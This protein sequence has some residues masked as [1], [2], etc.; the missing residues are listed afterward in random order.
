LVS[1]AGTAPAPPLARLRFQRG[2]VL[3]AA[4]ALILM[5]GGF[6][7][8]GPA[9]RLPPFATCSA[10]T[11][12]PIQHI[13]IVVK[14]NRSFDNMFGRFPRANGTVY[15]RAGNRVFKMSVTPDALKHD[16]GHGDVSTV[17]AMNGGRMNEFIRVSYARQ[18]VDNGRL[19]DVADSQFDEQSIPNY[20]AYARAYGLA[21]E[22]FSTI[23]ASSF[24][25]HLTTVAGS[26]LHT[27]DNPFLPVTRHGVERWQNPTTWGCDAQRGSLVHVSI[28]G[29]VRTVFPC[30]NGKTLVDEANAAGVS[31]R[32]YSASMGT[33]GYLWNALDAFRQ[34]RYSKQWLT[35][36][37]TPQGFDRDA[38]AGKLPAI[39]WLTPP[40]SG[41]DHPPES[42]CAG[43][44]WTVGEL[45][46]IMK[47]PDW[48]HT[49]VV[50]TW[51]DFGGFY[52]HVRPPSA[53]G[54]WAGSLGPRVPALVI[55]PYARPHL[56]YH[57]QLDFRSILKFAE[58][59][60]H[61]PHLMPYNRSVN[62]IGGMLDTHQAPA[63]KLLLQ[64]RACHAVA[65]NPSSIY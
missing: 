37:S 53:P 52:D 49:V 38:R 11:C 31:W 36:V 5:G 60:F 6:L 10:A 63:P 2:P 13:V 28:N 15:A 30:F 41:S 50:L 34:D 27:V 44:N 4:G 56:I 55:S 16:L 48:R 46:Q 32:Y 1:A 22:F 3:G 33:F 8:V 25:N 35:N 9:L 54:F 39:S 62:G 17:N 7:A 59:Q 23:A 18:R 21:D 24:P 45:N 51:D 40:L 12:G 65:V 57:R 42:E 29:A 26:A 61:L 58:N 14:E 20:F 19:Q 47:S 64:Q 43:E